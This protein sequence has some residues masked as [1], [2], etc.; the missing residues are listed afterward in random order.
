[1]KFGNH[2]LVVMYLVYFTDC[3]IGLLWSELSDGN[4]EYLH[5]HHTLNTCIHVCTWGACFSVDLNSLFQLV[6]QRP[7][8]SS[9]LKTG[10]GVLSTLTIL[11]QQGNIFDKVSLNTWGSW[12]IDTRKYLPE[13]VKY[14]E[15][16]MKLSTL[17]SP[18]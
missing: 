4:T 11:H 2:Y 3:V 1:M 6:F 7:S 5:H 9:L 16:G 15:W 14:S 17:S 13:R 18:S 8:G 12:R 10:P